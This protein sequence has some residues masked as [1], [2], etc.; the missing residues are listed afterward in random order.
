[1]AFAGI[2]NLSPS[3]AD[4]GSGI[5]NRSNFGLKGRIKN[6][7]GAIGGVGRFE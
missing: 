1:M 5:E 3:S 7:D 6:L 4:L 2:E